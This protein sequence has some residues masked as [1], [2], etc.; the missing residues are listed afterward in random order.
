MDASWYFISCELLKSGDST[1]ST[2]RN[3][4]K[5]RPEGDTGGRIVVAVATLGRGE[6]LS[7]VVR[8]LAK[9][10]RAPDLVLISA[11]ES[12]DFG[13]LQEDEVPFPMK[14]LLGV[15]G[16]CHQRNRALAELRGG[17]IVLFI[18]DDF[19]LAP[20]YLALLEAI[21]SEHADVVMT[22]GDVMA[23]GIMGP[24]FSL[25]EGLAALEAGLEAPARQTIET[26][27][28]AYG[29][30]MAVRVDTVIAN[31]LRFDEHLPL[32][33]WFEDVDFS[34]R[35]GKFGRIVK[36]GALRGVHLGTKS[37]R[38]PGKKLGYSQVANMV[39][40]NR[41]GVLPGWTALGNILRNSAANV[42]R[43]VR[44]VPYAD[45]RGR[46]HGNF[47]AFGDLLR[48]RLDPRR[49]IEI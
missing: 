17:D 7:P 6:I 22:T 24:G 19:L 43:S 45:H 38:T 18:D 13:D 36:C 41:K 47:I 44:P 15:R 21:F 12:N 32:Y 9:Q 42:V 46:L 26:T 27:R 4:D 3:P 39:Y 37:W 14:F 29:C 28:N 2:A 40:L 34:I 23:D 31:N 25:Q 16:A 20:D 1:I 33:A 48:G 30:N 8:H 49:I 10:T 5:E 11:T 35:A